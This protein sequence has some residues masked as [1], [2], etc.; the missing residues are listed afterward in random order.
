MWL[1]ALVLLP[2]CFVSR[3]WCVC[4]Y[5][6]GVCECM[7]VGMCICVWGVCGGGVGMCV[8]GVC[9]GGV[10]VCVKRGKGVTERKRVYSKDSNYFTIILD[11]ELLS[12]TV[13]GDPE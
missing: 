1:V 10:C 2:T 11:G 6:C 12:L 3:V 4:V 8:W 7:G 9:V 13:F 5:V